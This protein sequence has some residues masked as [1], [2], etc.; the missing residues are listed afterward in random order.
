M[1]FLIHYPMNTCVVKSDISIFVFFGDGFEIT[2]TY[3]YSIDVV[4]DV[5]FIFVVFFCQFHLIS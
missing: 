1:L 3:D 2:L 5:P 4:V